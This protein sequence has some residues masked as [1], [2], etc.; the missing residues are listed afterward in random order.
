MGVDFLEALTTVYRENPCAALPN[1]LWE[2]LPRL[3]GF[4]TVVGHDTNGQ[5]NRLEAANAESI[6]IYWRR[7]QRQPSLLMRRRL[8]TVQL[9]LMHQDFLDSDMVAGFSHTR[10][11]YFRLRHDHTQLAPPALPAGFRFDVV[12]LDKERDRVLAM[13]AHAE[14]AHTPAANTVESWMQ[15]PVFGAD[16]WLWAKDASIGLPVGLAAGVFDHAIGEVALQWVQVMPAY[17]RRGIGRALV[18]ELLRRAAE[19][20]RFSTVTGAFDF[21]QRENPGAFF[22]ASGFSGQD[23]WWLLGR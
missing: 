3:T 6:Y 13:I 20:A 7:E 10:Q 14:A 23:V 19:R 22:R 17:Q 2:T 9:A 5:I 1:S 21:H 11:P 18:D 15:P 4:E 12:Q 16:L 8:E